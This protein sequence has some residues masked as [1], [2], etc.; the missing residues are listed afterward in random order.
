M[1]YSK[2]TQG[3]LYYLP[4][5]SP[6]TKKGPYNVEV[7]AIAKKSTLELYGDFDIRSTFFDEVGIKTYLSMVGDETDIYICHPIKSYDPPDVTTDDFIF[8]PISIIDFANVDEYKTTTKFQFTLEGVR[9]HFDTNYQ[10]RQFVEEVQSAIPNAIKDKTSILSNDVLSIS[11]TQSEILV[12]NS[13]LEQEEN[14]RETYIRSREIQIETMKKQESEREMDYYNRVKN[15]VKRE[16]EIA[17]KEEQIETNIRKG[18]TLKSVGNTY[19]KFT[20]DFMNRIESIYQ[21][22]YIQAKELNAANNMPAWNELKAKVY[23]SMSVGGDISLQ[24]WKD[25]MQTYISTGKW[26]QALLDAENSVCPL[27]GSDIDK[28]MSDKI[29]EN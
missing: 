1:K 23:D 15:V 13:I 9:R 6:Y 22:I 12:K 29:K 14:D 11:N 2:L 28:M 5:I 26:D 20:N 17:I 4:F 8:I 18:E 3:H 16:D 24:I 7:S 21:I 27:C 19:L 10:S 25:M